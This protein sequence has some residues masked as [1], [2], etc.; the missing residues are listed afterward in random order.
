MYGSGAIL[1]TVPTAPYEYES[2]PRDFTIVGAIFLALL[3]DP[4]RTGSADKGL[5]GNRAE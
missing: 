2:S 5:D 3:R 1:L 4:A